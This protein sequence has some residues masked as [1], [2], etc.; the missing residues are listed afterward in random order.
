MK[1]RRHARE[2]AFQ[3]LY[4]IDINKDVTLENLYEAI[5]EDVD[6]YAKKI[7]KGVVEHRV[8]IDQAIDDKLEKWSFSRIATVEKT[9]LRIA[10]YEL[11]FE[12]EVPN[13]V[14]VNEAVELAKRF[15]EDQ[16][17][18]FINGVLSKFMKE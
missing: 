4:Q 14:A 12:D 2:K 11:M 10:V 7:I 16:S 13:K 6:E 9:V 1:E 15:N 3:G 8:E 5:D 18:K 17:G